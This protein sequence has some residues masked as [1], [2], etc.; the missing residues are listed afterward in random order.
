MKVKA[1]S[2]YPIQGKRGR[3]RVKIDFDQS[4]WLER[5]EASSLQEGKVL[6]YENSLPQ[7]RFEGI[8]L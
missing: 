5:K 2:G 8:F 1:R 3:C 7:I 4:L 6:I